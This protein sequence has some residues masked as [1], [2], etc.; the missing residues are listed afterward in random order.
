MNRPAGCHIEQLSENRCRQIIKMIAAPNGEEPMPGFKWMLGHCYDGITWGRWDPHEGV[1][2]T[3][4]RAFPNLSPRISE[5]NL[6]ELRIFGEETEILIWRLYDGFLGRRLSHCACTAFD[7]AIR[8]IKE[9]LVLVGD[10][11]IGRGMGFTH[12]GTPSGIQQVVP[13]DVEPGAFVKSRWPLRLTV[14]HYLCCDEE[15]GVIR[16]GASR[17]ADLFVVGV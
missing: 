6:I 10:R 16:I 7:E 12:V 2:V 8:P 5:D 15:S 9:E 4:D 14:W 17:L 3:G 11:V 1:W 13:I